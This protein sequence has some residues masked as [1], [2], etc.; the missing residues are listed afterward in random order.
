M[1]SKI[2]ADLERAIEQADGIAKRLRRAVERSR[3]D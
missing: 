3:R 2:V 1:T